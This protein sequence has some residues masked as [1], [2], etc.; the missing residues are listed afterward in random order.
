MADKQRFKI[1]EVP[2]VPEQ[3]ANQFVSGGFDGSSVAITLGTARMIPE[4]MGDMPKEGTIPAVYVTTRLMLSVPAALEMIKQLKGML[5]QIGL[6]MPPAR[7]GAPDSSGGGRI[8]S[9][10][11]KPAN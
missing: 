7:Q 3:Y 2:G 6:K 9:D 4:K 11:D 5:D 1:V 8:D 10:N